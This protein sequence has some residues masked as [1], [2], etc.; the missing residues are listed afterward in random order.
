MLRE[1]GTQNQTDSQKNISGLR[2]LI[3]AVYTVYI[4]DEKNHSSVV[5]AYNEQIIVKLSKYILKVLLTR[6]R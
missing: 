1:E 3:P 5:K 4:R 2:F 6:Q